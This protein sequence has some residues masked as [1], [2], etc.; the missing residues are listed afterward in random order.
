LTDP[1]LSAPE[2]PVEEAK[3]PPKPKP[4]FRPPGKANPADAAVDG[5]KR[6]FKPKS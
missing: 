1:I 6:L 3:T 4:S 5:L 2:T